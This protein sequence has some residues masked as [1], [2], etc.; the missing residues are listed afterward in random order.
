[1]NQFIIE[2]LGLLTVVVAICDI[3]LVNGTLKADDLKRDIP[4]PVSGS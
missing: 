3:N 2:H 4:D 1:M